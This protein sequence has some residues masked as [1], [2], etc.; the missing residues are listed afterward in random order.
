MAGMVFLGTPH[1]GSDA[2]LYGIWLAQAVGHDKTLLESLKKESTT[3]Y[4]IAQDFETSY[5]DADM[6]CFYENKKAFYG[7]WRTRVCQL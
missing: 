3:L 6:V 1:H 4:E 5:R 2:A 7:P